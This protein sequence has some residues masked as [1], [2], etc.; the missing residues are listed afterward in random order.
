MSNPSQV[1]KQTLLQKAKNFILPKIKFATTSAVA[2]SVDYVLYL[3]L[4]SYLFTPTVSN[5]IS[6]SCGMMINFVLQ[7][8]FIFSLQRRVSAALAL[9]ITFSLIGIGISTFLIYSLNH[10]AFFAKYQSITKLLATGLIFLYN[11]YTKRF[12]FERRI[13]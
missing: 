2:T 7:K 9:S 5:I 3:I 12:A 11:F 1:P 6:A 4:V 8:R 10:I 13:R